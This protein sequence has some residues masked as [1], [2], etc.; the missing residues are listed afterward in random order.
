MFARSEKGGLKGEGGSVGVE[1]PSFGGGV[2]GVGTTGPEFARLFGG[3]AYPGV[4]CPGE[5]CPGVECPGV[6]CPGVECPGVECPGEECPG[7][8]CPGE[9]CPGEECPGVEYPGVLVPGT[10]PLLGV[11]GPEPEII[12]VTPRGVLNLELEAEEGAEEAGVVE[13][14]ALVEAEVLFLGVVPE[15]S[16]GL[17]VD[18]G[19]TS[20]LE[21][22]R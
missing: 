19:G 4:A 11:V 10:R 15:E 2:V 6:E 3:V 18:P 12:E 8:E 9:E 5:E 7:V 14:E 20:L 16:V 1:G 21:D 17:P 13:V 22:R